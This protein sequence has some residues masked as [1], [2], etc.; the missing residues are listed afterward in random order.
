MG[1]DPGSSRRGWGGGFR[2][3]VEKARNSPEKSRPDLRLCSS[4]PH[5]T[6]LPSIE[7]H[8][9]APG[10]ARDDEE[11]VR[12]SISSCGRG[13]TSTRGSIVDDENQVETK[14]TTGHN[15]HACVA[16]THDNQPS[17]TM[18][19]CPRSQRQKGHGKVAS[20]RRSLPRHESKGRS[21]E[22][23]SREKE[24]RPRQDQRSAVERNQIRIYATEGRS[25]QIHVSWGDGRWRRINNVDGRSKL[26]WWRWYAC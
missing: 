13:W 10:P 6:S 24:K 8:V 22:S 26:T 20:E 21:D 3:G 2:N 15:D 11:K 18:V 12:M 5:H 4:S 7:G 17:Y 23:A 1:I 9:D 25:M 16:C 14:E 19:E